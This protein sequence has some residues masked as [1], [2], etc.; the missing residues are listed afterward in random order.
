MIES[1]ILNVGKAVK[2]YTV[3][4][5]VLFQLEEYLGEDYPENRSIYR[6]GD[7]K[8]IFP[9]PLPNILKRCSWSIAVEENTG[10]PL[11]VF[12]GID[13]NT[14]YD[15]RAYL[16]RYAKAPVFFYHARSGSTYPSYLYH[17]WTIGAWFS[18]AE[19][20]FI[21]GDSEIA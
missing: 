11:A 12:P 16:T 10:V 7:L 18:V 19:H 13:S 6:I 3:P 20:D 14:A 15:L 17:D 1:N 2:C 8:M 4:N 21:H 5:D 9:M